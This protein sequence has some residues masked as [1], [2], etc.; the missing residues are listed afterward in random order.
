MTSQLA[1][2]VLAYDTEIRTVKG[3]DLDA[4]YFRMVTLAAVVKHEEETLT[5][6]TLKERIVKLRKR[7]PTM[8]VAN[9]VEIMIY[10]MVEGRDDDFLAVAA[11]VLDCSQEQV[12]EAVAFTLEPPTGPTSS[13][14]AHDNTQDTSSEADNSQNPP[15]TTVDYMQDRHMS[16]A[17]ISD[18]LREAWLRQEFDK[19]LLTG[20][21]DEWECYKAGADVQLGAAME[22]L[23]GY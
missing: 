3:D 17:M 19:F 14:V 23:R 7:S 4:L 13:N 10:G 16:P 1:N 2:A 18:R 5:M 20:L 6:N 11:S 22:A 15:C 9:L 12:D 8:T 21:I